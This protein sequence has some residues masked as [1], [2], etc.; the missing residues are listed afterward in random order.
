ML[1]A[2]K[3]EKALGFDGITALEAE[4]LAKRRLDLAEADFE[5]DL[6]KRDARGGRKLDV[7]APLS[8]HRLT[9]VAACNVVQHRNASKVREVLTSFLSMGSDVLQTGHDGPIFAPCAECSTRSF[10]LP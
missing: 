1:L 7:M 5:I 3:A 2:I 10:E 4:G 8:R 6:A 9:W